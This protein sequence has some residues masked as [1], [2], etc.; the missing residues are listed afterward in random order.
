MDIQ[1]LLMFLLIGLVAGWLAGKIM[2][3]GGFGLVGNIIV[4]A[5][6]ALLGGWLFGLLGISAGG[7][8]GS[9]VTALVGA[10]VLLYLVRLIKKA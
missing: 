3:G 10:I 6:G 2:K 9:L 4:G 5:I 1:S 7:L 8:I